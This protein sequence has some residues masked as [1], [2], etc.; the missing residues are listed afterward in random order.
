MEKSQLVQYLKSMSI[1]ERGRFSQYLHSPYFNRGALVIQLFEYLC[2]CLEEP[3]TKRSDLLS[4]KEV[5]KRLYPREDFVPQRLRRV[6]MELNQHLE[7]FFVLESSPVAPASL[8]REFGLR[9]QLL[10]RGLLEL[11]Q[12]RKCKKS[13]SP[14]QFQVRETLLEMFLEV[15]M[16]EYFI[17]SG[18]PE[19]TLEHAISLL[20][21]FYLGFRLELLTSM[22]N[23][24]RIYGR[25]H[26]FIFMDLVSRM[27]DTE[28]AHQSDNVKLWWHVFQLHSQDHATPSF[29]YL[30]D[31]LLGPKNVLPLQQL[32]QI[33]GFMLNHINR[34][35]ESKNKYILI[36]QL[37]KTM[38]EEG[39]LY[40]KEKINANMF[41]ATIRSACYAGQLDWAEEFLKS[42][43]PSLK[44]DESIQQIELLEAMIS[45][46]RGN[47][48]VAI[49]KIHTI[50]FRT[51]RNE[52]YLKTLQLMCVYQLSM[53]ED[54]FRLN[55][56]FRKYLSYNNSMGNNFSMLFQEFNQQLHR[57]GKARFHGTTLPGDIEE[58]LKGKKA[59]EKMWLLQ[60]L[61]KLTQE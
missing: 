55:E 37:L 59:A 12:K 33:R 47:E 61:G 13:V 54:F 5:F 3:V 15:Q 14:S 36:W 53:D 35:T 17:H 46:F 23:K 11:Y 29:S 6:R 58:K 16:N 30:S 26:S 9:Q 45:F 52:T 57:L 27:I 34:T 32:R 21:Q 51:V 28:G 1:K 18:S 8:I 10:D 22:I 43:G 41:R 39:T 31:F 49:T 24:E 7:N 48:F 19:D 38:L 20:D 2:S 25:K 50:R 4:I 42:H 60:Q 40:V 56:A 44:G